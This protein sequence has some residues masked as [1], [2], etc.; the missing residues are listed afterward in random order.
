[1]GKKEKAG[2]DESPDAAGISWLYVKHGAAQKTLFNASCGVAT[3]LDTL[4]EAAAVAPDAVIDLQDAET[5]LLLNMPKQDARADAAALIRPT[6]AYVLVKP[7]Y[8][9]D[10][11]NAGAV[12]GIETLYQPPEGEELPPSPP[13]PDA[14]KKK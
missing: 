11:P 13:P 12:V 5:G 8:A 14:K 10:G 2:A 7:Q 6:K 3:L 4:K 1:M 9:A